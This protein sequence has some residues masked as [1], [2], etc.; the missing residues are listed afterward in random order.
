MARPR[1]MPKELLDPKGT[2]DAP[3]APEIPAPL[4][5]WEWKPS[6]GPATTLKE[7]MIPPIAHE[8]QVA[9]RE[10]HPPQLSPTR[11][12]FLL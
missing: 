7:E 2:E 3:S 12:R 5:G 8:S 4:E 6:R 10:A 9:A 11:F 1:Q